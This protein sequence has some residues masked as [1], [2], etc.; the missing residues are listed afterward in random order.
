[1][2]RKLYLLLSLVMLASMLL[3][4][5]GGAA[6]ATQPPAVKEPPA[7]TQAP[8]TQAPAATEP[9]VPARSGTVTI[10]FTE[11]PDNLNPMYTSMSFSGYLRP[12]YLKPSW[13]FDENAKP[14]PVLVKEIPSTD[15]GGLSADGKTI[16]L[17]LRDDVKWSDGEPLT[18]ED[19]VF[20]FDMIMSD[21]NTPLGR[22]P[23][24]KFVDSVEAPDPTTVVIN[25]KQPFAAWLT[26][27]FYYILPKHVLQPVF[28]TDGTIDN[29]EW[30][31]NPTVSLGPFTFDAWETGSHIT[32]K[33][34]PDWIKPP[35]VE[36]IFVRIVPDDAAQEAAIIAGDTDI[37]VFLSSDQIQKL[38]AGG[39]V[40]VV[41]VTSG[42][43]EGWFLN[44]NKDTA[45]PFMLDVNVRK[46]IA[47]ATDRF[48]LVKDLLVESI[49]PVNVTFWDT[50][51]PYQT[52][53]LQ[54]YPYDPEQ[55]K[56][57]LDTAGWTDSDGDGIRD[58]MVDGKKVDMI[59]R[60]A[61]TQRELRK[62]IQAVV[63]QQ[64]KQV[65][66]GAELSNY[67]NDVFWTGYNDGGPQALGEYDIAQFSSSG[68]Y[69]PDPDTEGFMCAQIVNAD[70]P[71]GTNTQGYCNPKLDEL[72]KAQA[73]EVDP[74]KRKELYNQ[75][76]QIM[77]DDYIYV[78][79]WKDPDLWSVSSRL[80]NVKFSGVYPFW[81]AYEW[82]IAE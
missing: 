13:D 19:Y 81:N 51:P 14:V 6:P 66:I 31:R 70:N 34:N 10:T 42:Y 65:G 23:Y 52:D 57:L 4:A 26:S 27:L 45:R 56:Q 8:A 12:F 2:K 74:A 68:N 30:N 24:D 63:E 48:T 37:G 64:W 7:A 77:Y 46:A 58:K 50:T 35:K 73:V 29:A 15:N 72:F 39:K 17:K 11:E 79:F 47:L 40:K 21:K 59:I 61:T 44:V 3:A 5:C 78:G 62:N 69:L 49:N 71:D 28:D 16:T 1:M 22:Y 38:E 82:E 80:T 32:F 60:Y 55:A 67:S 25:L 41:P 76:E 33:A 75:I 18:A 54:P 53:T 43:N 9:P 36:Q 20:T